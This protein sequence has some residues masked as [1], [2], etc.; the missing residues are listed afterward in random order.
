MGHLTLNSLA[1]RS[2]AVLHLMLESSR[3]LLGGDLD[4]SL[5]ELSEHGC[6]WRWGAC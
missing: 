1:L 4:A 2:C 6:G 5:K 3:A